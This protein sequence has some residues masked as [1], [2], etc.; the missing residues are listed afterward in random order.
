MEKLRSKIV[1][2]IVIVLIIIITIFSMIGHVYADFSLFGDDSSGNS[3][4]SSVS[5]SVLAALEESSADLKNMI[6]ITENGYE[7]NANY[8]LRIMQALENASINTYAYGFRDKDYDITQADDTSQTYKTDDQLTNIIDKY[9]RAELKNMLPDLGDYAKTAINGNVVVKR[10]TAKFGTY[11]ADESNVTVTNDGKFDDGITLKYVPYETLK[12]Y[13]KKTVG[14][15]AET[16]QY[17]KYFSINPQGMKLCVLVSNEN[18]EWYYNNITPERAID[19]SGTQDPAGVILKAEYY[20]NASKVSSTFEIKEY[21]YLN[22]LEQTAT[23]INYFIAMHLITQDVDFMNEFVELCNKANSYIEIGFLESTESQFT[24]Y[25]YGTDDK[26]ITRGSIKSTY[27]VDTWNRWD[28]CKDTEKEET[29]VDPIDKKTKTRTIIVH[30]PHKDEALVNEYTG[31]YYGKE[32]ELYE[33]CLNLKYAGYKLKNFLN[34]SIKNTGDLYL[35]KANTWNMEYELT[36]T[37]N[38][39]ERPFKKIQK[40]KKIEFQSDPIE[41]VERLNSYPEKY[42]GKHCNA[43]HSSMKYEWKNTHFYIYESFANWTN[44]YNVYSTT[45]G[46]YKIDIIIKLLRKY[47]KV[48]NNITNASYLL[49]S[50]LNQNGNTQELEKYM[51]YILSNMSGYE[52]LTDNTKNLQF[53]IAIG[54]S[55]D[56]L[57]SYNNDGSTTKYTTD[58]DS[59]A[60]SSG[61]IRKSGGSGKTAWYLEKQTTITTTD[62]DG[63]FSITKKYNYYK[64]GKGT[65]ICG[66]ASLATCLSGLGYSYTPTEISPNNT[67]AWFSWATTLGV[68]ATRYTNNLRGKLIEHLSTG[69]PA[70]V[71]IKPNKAT[72]NVYNTTG[73]H[74]IAVVGIKYAGNV[75]VYVLDP[76][77]SRATRTENYIDINTVLAYADEIRTF[78]K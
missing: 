49:F 11:N 12:E 21:E 19:D 54:L 31:D 28:C 55:D 62:Q 65:N 47:P 36:P 6:S 48:E 20:K 2:N 53:N 27:K 30:N 70:I 22:L 42:V 67:N 15:Y 13:S 16:Q 71:H 5:T 43:N 44:K 8:A 25:N 66:R 45:K 17:L 10:Y 38:G 1:K 3:S 51:R 40:T 24:H 63:N 72:D 4:G 57:Y 7:V 69:N 34:V 50:L 23:P 59:S 41:Y 52:Y 29:Y 61:T 46:G 60:K 35:I 78:S 18:Y 64:Q 14:S 33:T 56:N 9:I 58:V 32:D 74:F 39:V 68:K 77:S 75:S 73:G 37:V 76:G 26:D